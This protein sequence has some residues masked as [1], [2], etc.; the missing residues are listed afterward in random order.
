MKPG[1]FYKCVSD[2]GLQTASKILKINKSNMV[3]KKSYDARIE[4]PWKSKQ[5]DWKFKAIL[6]YISSSIQKE[7][8]EKLLS[9]AR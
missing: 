6:D 9:K 4:V 1:C 8:H 5:K 3:Y 7:L 2:H